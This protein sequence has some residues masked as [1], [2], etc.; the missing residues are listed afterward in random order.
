MQLVTN[1]PVLPIGS[2]TV[3]GQQWH[4]AMH[5]IEFVEQ[6]Q[7]AINLTRAERAKKK[8]STKKIV[9]IDGSSWEVEKLETQFR[10]RPEGSE[11]E[12]AWIDCLDFK[13]D[14][15]H[16]RSLAEALFRAL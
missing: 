15:A 8:T 14:G 12:D 5:E 16:A 4:V 9:Q 6:A 3:S 1:V 13:F 7:F 11:S 10:M 2:A